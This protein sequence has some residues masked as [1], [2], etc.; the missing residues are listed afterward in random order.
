MRL[1]HALWFLLLIP[2][3][4]FAQIVPTS[5]GYNEGIV[6]ETVFT[7]GP[8]GKVNRGV[9]DS[10]GHIGLVF[11][12]EGMTR[13]HRVHGETGALMWTR[14]IEGTAGFG[15]A[16]YEAQDGPDYIVTGGSGNSQERWMA[17]LDGADGSIIWSQIYDTPGG[18]GSYDGLRM[19]VE[20]SDGFLYGAGFVGGDEA[21]TI[22]V[23]YGGEGNVVKVDP[24]DGALIWSENVPGSEYV[25]A[26]AVAQGTLYGATASWEEDLSIA[27]IGSDGAVLWQEGL[28]G[29]ADIIPYDLATDGSHLYYGGHRGR[30]GAGDPFDFSCVKASLDGQV[31][32][33][34]HYANPRGYSL[35]H[36]RNE[37]YGVKAD[38]TGVYLFGGTGDESGYSEQIAPFESSDVWNGWVLKVNGEGDILHSGVFCQDGVNTATEYGC[39]IDGGYVIFND[40]DA[41]GDTEVGVM[42]IAEPQTI[43]VAESHPASGLVDVVHRQG[44]CIVVPFQPVRCAVQDAL[45]RT[46]WAG[47]VEGPTELP[48]FGPGWCFLDV[49]SG[50]NREVHR[51]LPR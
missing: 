36:I 25:L 15:I 49:R 46:V 38:A 41:G 35:S 51:L 20:G 37:L 6:W 27:A 42:R 48:P 10:E 26:V 22:F 3:S 8:A 24:D 31:E 5:S 11:M 18:W 32:W 34:G 50:L 44:A 30:P 16:V 17:R 21:G 14:S 40:T 45:G 23:V 39:L 7:D 33:V 12:P 47:D 4:F 9:S 43:G 2:A 28:D 19:A 29:T 1:L 13:V